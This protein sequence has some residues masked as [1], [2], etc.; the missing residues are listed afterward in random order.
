V[1]AVGIPDVMGVA[2]IAALLG[3]SRSRADQIT[4]EKDFPDG[5]RLRMGTVW[6]TEDVE[7]WIAR[8]RPPK[9]TV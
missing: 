8:R 1:H 2:E 9:D 3:V 4:R 6:S 5:R 7:A